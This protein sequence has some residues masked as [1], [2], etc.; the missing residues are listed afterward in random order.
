MN[1]KTLIKL[2]YDKIR[3][4]IASLCGFEGGRSLSLNMTPQTNIMRLGE[5]LDE[6][7]QAMEALRFQEPSFLNGL[8][9]IDACLYKARAGGV[10]Q[11][12]ELR[13]VYRLAWAAAQA[14]RYLTPPSRPRLADIAIELYPLPQLE[15]S[16]DRAIGEDEEVRDDASDELRQIRRQIVTLRARIR[17]YLQGFI[18]STSNQKYLQDT[19]VTERDGRYVVPVKQEFRSEVKGVVHDESASGATVFIEPLPVVEQNNRIRTLQNEERRELERILRDL[20]QQVAAC[21]DELAADQELLAEVDLIFARARLAYKTESFRPELNNRGLVE[22]SRARHPLLGSGAVPVDIQLGGKFDILVITG[23]NTGGKTVVLKTLGLLTL[24]AM[25]GLFVPARENSRLSIFERIFVDIGDEQSIEQS[26]STFSSHMS[27]II[28]ILSQ[29]NQ[30]S[31]VLLDEMGAGTD[32]VEGAALA[33][34]ILEDLMSKNCRAVV[35]T[36]QSELKNFAFQHQRV[37]NACVEFD[38]RSLQ[39]TYKLT[40]GMPGQ[41]NALVI[42]KSLGLDPRLAKRAIELVPKNEQEIGYMIRQLHESRD[43]YKNSS[44]ELENLKADLERRQKELEEE[45]QQHLQQREE[46]IARAREEASGYLRRI[47]SEADEAIKE[48]KE[49]LKKRDPIPKWHEIENSRQKLKKLERQE[50]GNRVSLPSAQELKPG[51]NVYIHS[52]QQKGIVLT[53]PDPQGEVNIQVGN[54]RLYVHRDQLQHCEAAPQPVIF[55]RSPAFLEKAQK[56]SREIDLRGKMAEEALEELDRYMEDANLVGLDK[57]RIIH[58]KGTGALR[59]AI[60][61][62]LS[63]HDY[64]ARYND[65]AREEGG[66]GVTVVELKS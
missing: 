1:E 8:S 66:H 39:P 12:G 57:I 32:P 45:H 59:K 20:S 15:K 36:H 38:P 60:R 18:R 48:L 2:E 46:I 35:T 55:N 42:A 5:M 21:V 6:T 61:S 63:D 29:V 13:A 34:V 65:G 51:D 25:S 16:I 28:D 64:V 53:A 62:Y 52:I 7:E 23:P 3:E 33:R 26:L 54:V 50:I 56:I 4:Q 14:V 11:P 24:M 58:G 31:L 19:L 43:Q 27:N 30:H 9:R 17:D 44:R 49:T 37:E 10:L 47:K 22:L 41:S 40:I